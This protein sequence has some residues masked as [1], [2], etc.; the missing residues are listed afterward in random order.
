MGLKARPKV[1]T[2]PETSEGGTG[3]RTEGWEEGGTGRYMV[4]RAGRRVLRGR[5]L[6]RRYC[7]NPEGR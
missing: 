5:V 4:R 1:G 6:C 7:R 3:M 2:D